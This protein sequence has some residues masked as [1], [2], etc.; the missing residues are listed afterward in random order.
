MPKKRYL[1]TLDAEEREQLEHLL[2][3]GPTRPVK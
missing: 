1:V 3:V 2:Q